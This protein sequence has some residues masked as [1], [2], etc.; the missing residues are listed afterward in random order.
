MFQSLKNYYHVIQAMI[1]VFRYGNPANGMIVIGVTGTDGKTT[2]AS[3]IYHILNETGHKTALISTVA[4]YFDG[5]K[6]DTG[7]HVSTPHSSH[8]QSYISKAKEA[9]TTHL[10][11]EVT[12]HALDQNRVWGIPF[13]I[14]VLTNVSYEHLDYHKTM[15]SYMSAKLKLLQLARIA[16][17]NRDDSSYDF[18]AKKLRHKNVITYG[19]TGSADINPKN[20]PFK[21]DL[22]GSYNV[23]N[24]LAAL[25]V[26]EALGLDEKDAAKAVATFVLP[27]GRYEVVFDN[28]FKIII[29][30]AHTP[31]A[32]ESV[33]RAAKEAGVKGRLI[34]VFGSAGERDKGKRPMMGNVSQKLADWSIITSED[35]RHES[36]ELIASEILSGMT[37]KKD[38]V[39]SIIDRQDAITRAVMMA[40]KGDVVVITGKGHEKSM[41][42]GHGEEPWS[43]Q[44]AVKKALIYKK[45]REEGV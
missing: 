10:V 42:F 25:A 7:F 40:Q 33:L 19:L 1:A 35:V 36:P 8:L 37:D 31:H 43:D 21:S 41:N 39:D 20:H 27:E 22:V 32:L 14:G 18:M 44:E 38:A 28:N 34:H 12:S 16:I 30:F 11:L 4:A 45:E 5:K 29:D 6:L 26:C 2:T 13:A 17:I 24:A 23:S 9:G 3:M 15:K